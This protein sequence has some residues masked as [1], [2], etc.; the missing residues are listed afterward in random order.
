VRE[1]IVA[2]EYNADFLTR[3]GDF[4]FRHSLAPAF[5]IHGVTHRFPIN[6]NRARL[7]VFEHVHAPQQRRFP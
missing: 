4:T 2:L 3:R 5:A 6:R 1:Q 7:I